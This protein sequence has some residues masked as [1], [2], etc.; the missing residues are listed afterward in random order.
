M[1]DRCL[2]TRLYTGRVTLFDLYADGK[3]DARVHGVLH[4]IVLAPRAHAVHVHTLTHAGKRR[5]TRVGTDVDTH[6]R[7]RTRKHARSCANVRAHVRTRTRTRIQIWHARAHAHAHFPCTCIRIPTRVRM[8]SEI[9]LWPYGTTCVGRHVYT[10]RGWSWSCVSCSFTCS[11]S[12][13]RHI[14]Y[15]KL[16]IT[17]Y[18]SCRQP[19]VC[20][21]L[22]VQVVETR[23]QL[24]AAAIV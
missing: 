2:C 12:S 4:Y 8:H 16:L 21:E 22:V 10:A 11:G 9:E 14:T 13:G 15:H 6:A 18:I 5:Q 17:Y 23:Q 24:P 7:T 19:E 20:G 3:A 1:P